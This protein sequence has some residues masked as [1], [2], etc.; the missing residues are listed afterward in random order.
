MGVSGSVPASDRVLLAGDAAGLVN[1]L[2]GEGIS[3]AMSS[4]RAVAEAVL[5]SPGQCAAVYRCW[6][7]RTLGSF[8][9][10]AGVLHEV[11]V[12]RPRLR[13]LAAGVLTGP[14]TARWLAPGFAIWW[15]DLLDGAHSASGRR[16]AAAVAAGARLATSRSPRS[17]DLADWVAAA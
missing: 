7:A 1:P 12:A 8:Q 9:C 3:E 4:G 15:N 5:A 6:L 11:L 13:S 17:A 14:A 16:A 2:Q 10:S